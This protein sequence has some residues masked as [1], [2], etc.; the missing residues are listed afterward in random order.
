MNPYLRPAPREDLP[1]YPCPEGHE[2]HPAGLWKG[3]QMEVVYDPRLHD[4]LFLREGM[5]DPEIR[6]G[7]GSTGWAH[8]ESD[9]QSEM[10]IRDRAAA[11]QAALDCTSTPPARALQR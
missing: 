8:I 9:G 6:D 10:W 4:V 5:D 2:V 3:S 11:A 7:L 1:P